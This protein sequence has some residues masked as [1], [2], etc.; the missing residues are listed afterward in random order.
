MICM[1]PVIHAIIMNGMI[2]F[3]LN[4]KPSTWPCGDLFHNFATGEDF[5]NSFRPFRKSQPP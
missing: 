3:V 2:R 5:T 4:S 1:L